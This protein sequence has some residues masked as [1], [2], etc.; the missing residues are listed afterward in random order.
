MTTSESKLNLILEQI[1]QSGR[2]VGEK[3]PQKQ[4]QQKWQTYSPSFFTPLYTAKRI[5]VITCK[6]EM[7]VLNA[8][9]KDEIQGK[10][11]AAGFDDLLLNS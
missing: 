8:F 10:Q 3:K 7:L 5:Y 11:R 9:L 4:G 2:T 6:F 1:V